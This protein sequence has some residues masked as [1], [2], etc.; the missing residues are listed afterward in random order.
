MPVKFNQYWRVLRDARNPYRNFI[1]KEFIPGINKLE[2]HTVAAW[3]VLVGGYSEIIFEGVSSD[4]DHIERALQ[5]PQYKELNRG[6][7]SASYQM[8]PE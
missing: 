6:Y 8:V 1:I 2:I 3:S 5:D 7:K 4:L